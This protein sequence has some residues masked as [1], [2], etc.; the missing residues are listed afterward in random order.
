ML[1]G[2]DQAQ[3]R[4]GATARE[5]TVVQDV[6]AAGILT[7][8]LR[9]GNTRLG[10]GEVMIEIAALRIDYTDIDAA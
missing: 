4:I 9:T 7:D 8:R 6:D 10:L 2:A 1:D 5:V 3:S